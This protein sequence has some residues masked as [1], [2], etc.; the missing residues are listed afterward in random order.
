MKLHEPKAHPAKKIIKKH[1]ISTASVA[2][3][4][5]LSFTYTANMLNGVMRITP[6]NEAKLQK[7]I[8]QLEGKK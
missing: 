4:L 8:E 2:K 1:G 7:L 3:Y 5:N 6:K